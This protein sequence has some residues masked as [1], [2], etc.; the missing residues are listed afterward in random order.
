MR[1]LLILLLI[2]VAVGAPQWLP[3]CNA[4]FGFCVQRPAFMVP[5]LPPENGDGQEFRRGAAR[6]VV[7]GAHDVNVFTLADLYKLA[8]K[9]MLVKYKALRPNFYVVSGLDGDMVIYEYKRL[10]NGVFYT[11]YLEYPLS[12]KATYDPLIKPMLDSFRIKR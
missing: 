10:E 5:Q 11:L 12:Q 3:Y 6:L 4:R 7:S 9:K 1:W 2:G 8:Q